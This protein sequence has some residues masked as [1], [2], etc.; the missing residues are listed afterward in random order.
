MLIRLLLLTLLSALPLLA[1]ALPAPPPAP[2]KAEIQKLLSDILNAAPGHPAPPRSLN[3]V[4]L[5]DTK[6]HGP[7][8]HDYPRWQ[9][10]WGLLFGGTNASKAPAA[11][12]YGPDVVEPAASL[13]AP[14]VKVSLA[15]TWPDAAAWKRADLVVA[16]CY[17]NWTPDRLAQLR[18]YLER[19]GGL[20]LIHS[21]TWTKPKPSAEV[22]EVVGVGGFERWRHASF[23]VDIWDRD[24][25]ICRGLPAQF[26]LEDESYW[27]PT[28][29]LTNTTAHALA[30]G[31]E[32]IKPDAPA[33]AKQAYFWTYTLGKGRVF[34]CVPGH[35]TWTFDD[36]YFRLLVFHGMAWAAADNPTRFDPLVLR[37]ARVK[38]P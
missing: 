13:G 8:A 30:G 4:L 3:M 32:Q 27:P 24:N 16:F 11:N 36:P 18:Q 37:G 7:E 35:F 19:G 21:A 14:Q 25:P 34:G 5:S 33:T 10:R 2:S 17:I 20:V 12:L 15:Q 26:P 28:P 6:D 1:A 38:S 31:L 22:A 23:Q 9:E 29:F